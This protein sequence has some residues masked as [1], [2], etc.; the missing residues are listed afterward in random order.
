MGQYILTSL[1]VTVDGQQYEQIVACGCVAD[2]VQDLHTPSP[3]S[4]Y[5]PTPENVRG[6][7]K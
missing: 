4:E 3:S 2:Q 5:R 6:G 1:L 7:D